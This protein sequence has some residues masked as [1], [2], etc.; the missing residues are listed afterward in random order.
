LVVKLIDIEEFCWVKPSV[1]KVLIV[2]GKLLEKPFQMDA[3]GVLPC[4]V[5]HP[6]RRLVIK[7][8]YLRSD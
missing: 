5:I 6:Y 3:Q 4:D 1:R 2:F 7:V 8:L